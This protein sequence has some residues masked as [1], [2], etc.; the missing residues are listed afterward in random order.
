KIAGEAQR[1]AEW[2]IHG[3]I[4]RARP[5]VMCI[6]HTHPYS[7]G[8]MA[9]IDE[10]LVP[11]TRAGAYFTPQVPRYRVTSNLIIDAGMGRG[12]AEALGGADAVLMQNHG[13]TYCGPTIAHCV[14]A[15]V[16]LEQACAAQLLANGSGYGWAPATGAGAARLHLSDDD[17]AAAWGFLRRKAARPFTA[18][19]S[20]AGSSEDELT[21]AHRVLANEGHEALCA[22]AVAVR[23]G[24][25]FT[26]KRAGL[27]LSEIRDENSLH[28]IPL[29][30]MGG[31]GATG[32]LPEGPL[33]SAVFSARDDVAAAVWTEAPAVAVFA[34]TDAPLSPAGDEGK[35][36]EGAWARVADAGAPAGAIA[37]ALGDARVVLLGNA[38]ALV[39]GPSVKVAVLR[40]LFIEKACAQQLAAGASRYGWGW[41]PDSDLG[42]A[43]MTLEGQRQVDGFWNFYCRKLARREQGAPLPGEF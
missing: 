27:A 10:A 36:F 2:P 16:L 21:L 37:D 20:P 23:D 5:D 3:E 15:G 28:T 41:L 6:G 43:G 17:V 39:V 38:G 33:F 7:A 22:G 25:E 9:M 24:A 40:A 18:S 1:H 19:P 30:G 34:A 12:L 29:S 4:F 31:D 14:I 11:V 42:V 26:T 8:V 13:V 32:A 35:H